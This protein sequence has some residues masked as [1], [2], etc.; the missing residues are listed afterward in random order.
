MMPD[1]DYGLSFEDL[2]PS[3]QKRVVLDVCEMQ[4]RA[5]HKDYDEA[6][7]PHLNKLAGDQQFS[8][9]IFAS[10]DPAEALYQHATRKESLEDI[11]GS[12]GD[13]DRK[14]EYNP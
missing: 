7:R 4:A 3:E 9:E 1:N 5:R 13:G 12:I 14:S 6:V 11:L 10:H 2:S 8:S